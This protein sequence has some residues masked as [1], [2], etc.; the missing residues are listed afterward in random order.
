ML[1][2][3]GFNENQQG[4]AVGDEKEKKYEVYVYHFDGANIAYHELDKNLNLKEI[5]KI[6]SEEGNLYL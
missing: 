5:P 6:Y 3:V 2:N 1:L 4:I